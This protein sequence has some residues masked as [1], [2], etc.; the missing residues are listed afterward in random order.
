MVEV[1]GGRGVEHEVAC[2]LAGHLPFVAE[3]WEPWTEERP[4]AAARTR[5]EKEV[6]IMSW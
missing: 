4:K 5:E 1:E 6:M 3:N 2:A